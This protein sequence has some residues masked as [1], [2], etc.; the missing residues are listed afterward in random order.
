MCVSC[1]VSRTLPPFILE[2]C[3][4][5]FSP[6]SSPVLFTSAQPSCCLEALV[7]PGRFSFPFLAAYNPA[8]W[9]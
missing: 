8:R 2:K 5:T 1:W 6:T 9:I 3:P 7:M 4:V